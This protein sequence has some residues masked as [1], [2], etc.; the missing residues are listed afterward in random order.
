MDYNPSEDHR[1]LLEQEQGASKHRRGNGHGLG[2]LL[3]EKSLGRSSKTAT[4]SRQALFQKNKRSPRIKASLSY[5]AIEN[6]KRGGGAKKIKSFN[7]TAKMASASALLANGEN[8][9]P[10]L[11]SRQPKI[12]K[13]VS[14]RKLQLTSG[15]NSKSRSNLN[16]DKKILKE[17]GNQNLVIRGRT[18][19][20]SHLCQEK[21]ST[22]N[23]PRYLTRSKAKISKS[24]S[25]LV[26]F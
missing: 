4:T 6:L 17:S 18:K 21:L 3:E 26:E 11:R 8:V 1:H 19:S 9:T 10:N 5:A 15:S 2:R 12:M 16:S 22:P 25:D 7:S 24:M 23:K 13:T 20:W 14:G